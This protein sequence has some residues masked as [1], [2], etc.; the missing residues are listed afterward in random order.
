MTHEC[1]YRGLHISCI[2]SLRGKEDMRWM[3]YDDQK[4]GKGGHH[5]VKN[6]DDVATDQKRDF[7]IIGW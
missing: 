3:A 7:I 4:E 6:G 1:L 2:H 5:I